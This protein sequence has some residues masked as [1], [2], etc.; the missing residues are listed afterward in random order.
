MSDRSEPVK[1]RSRKGMASGDGAVART[2]SAG[3]VGGAGRAESTGGDG[4]AGGPQS[5]GGKT[6]PADGVAWAARGQLETMENILCDH[7]TL[8]RAVIEGTTDAVFVKDLQGHYLLA[9]ASVA[10]IVKRPLGEIIGSADS[11]LF[12]AETAEQLMAHDARVMSDGVTRQFE[13]EIPIEGEVRTFLST[14]AAHRDRGGK[15]V[16]LIGISRDITKLK[17][18]EAAVRQSEERLARVLE[19]AMD[20]I[21]TMDEHRTIVLFNTAAEDVFRCPAEQAVGRSFD[22]FASEGLREMVAGCQKAFER[23]GTKKRYVWV[24][25]G[26]TAV[27]ADGE[28]FPV[29]ATFSRAEAANQK[30]Y[31]MIL[32]DVNDRQRTEEEIRRLRLEN[33]Y[34]R[35]EIDERA[36]LGEIVG[37]SKSMANVLQSV[38]Q[39]ANTDATVLIT[40]ETGTGKELI[41]QAIH[42]AS[43]RKDRMLVKVNCAALPSGLI[44]SEL[45]G[46]EKGAFTGAVSRKSGRFELADGGTLFLDEVGDLPDDLQ[47]K[48]LRVL[49]NG[50][51]DRLGGTETIKVDVRVVAA[52]NRDLISAVESGR[53]R[54]DLYYRL[55]VFPVRIPPLR[56]RPEDIP[57]LVRHF[58]MK[59]NS[60]MGKSVGVVSDAIIDSLRAY[61]WPGNIRELENVIE[62]AV[63]L[64]PGTHL[65]LGEWPPVSAGAGR[66]PQALALDDIQRQHITKVLDLVG[67]R[68]S[69]TAGAAQLLG[70]KPTTLQSRM[71]RLGIV[72]PE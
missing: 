65:E 39:V 21:V 1:R 64:S 9:N 23:G 33:V 14:K 71:K 6:L 41:A 28:R 32:R 62:R 20:A 46:H 8:L 4:R 54:P 10:R 70:L 68:V 12:S 47:A 37:V 25:E 57:P 36:R 58:V 7:C 35:E 22:R 30:L 11:A 3:G 63:I 17:R 49:Q 40:G 26:L 55:N 60:K 50:E 31:T 52:T 38:R 18:A 45:F 53:F 27:R 61:S 43:P 16:G 44:E 72:R 56:E 19:S 51:F 15:V 66:G 59:F 13:A 48:L 29:E 42:D 24:P 5:A 2:R 34:L 69:G 67:W